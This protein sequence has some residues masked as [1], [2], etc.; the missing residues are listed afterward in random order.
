MKV[1]EIITSAMLEKLGQGC[2]PWRMEWRPSANT[3]ELHREEAILGIND[4]LLACQ[5]YD[6]PHS[7]P[8]LVFEQSCIN[9]QRLRATNDDACK[10]FVGRI[11]EMIV[12]GWDNDARDPKNG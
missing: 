6:S 9:I 3:E 12:F 5:G 7:G 4:F 10:I 2:I 1:Y 11:N 8:Y